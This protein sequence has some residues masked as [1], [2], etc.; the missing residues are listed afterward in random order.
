MPGDEGAGGVLAGLLASE[1]DF[2]V[3]GATAAVMQGA[4]VVTF[5]LDIVHSRSPDNVERLLSWLLENG[6]HHRF[7]LAN[8][9]LPPTREALLG[10]GHINLATGVGDIDVLCELE[11]G[12]GFDQ[13]LL[14]TIEVAS[15]VNRVRVLSLARLIAAKTHAGRPKDRAMLPLLIATLDEQTKRGR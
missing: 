6:A 13:L 14:E 7:D 2:I 12:Q 1:V 4:P 8:R 5:D 9:M 10:R 3:V 15:G 11:P